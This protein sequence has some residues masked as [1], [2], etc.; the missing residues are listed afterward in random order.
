M[1]LWKKSRSGSLLA[2]ALIGV[3]S[4][5]YIWSCYP[6]S[7][8]TSTGDYDLIITQ[9]DPNKDFSTLVTYFMPDSVEHIVP[10]GEEDDISREYDEQ[11]LARVAKNMNDLNYQP[12]DIASV[13]TPDIGIKVYATSTTW[14]GWTWYP[15]WWGG[16]WGGYPP[17]WGPWYPG[18]MVPYEFT[19]GSVVIDMYDM[20]AYLPDQEVTPTIWGGGINGLLG[21]SKSNIEYRLD[22]DIDQC[23]RQSPYLGR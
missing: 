7:G 23:F 4:A 11:I 13:D 2:L 19:T 21:D 17:G 8:L 6:D 16:W 9:Y 15:G 20:K 14:Q 18:Y 5:L 22:R 12:W 3:L 10:E 1:K